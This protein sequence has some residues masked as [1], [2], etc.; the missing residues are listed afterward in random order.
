MSLHPSALEAV[1]KAFVQLGH[2][3]QVTRLTNET[4][5]T[6]EEYKAYYV[7]NES[8]RQVLRDHN[9]GFARREM[10]LASYFTPTHPGDQLPHHALLPG[11]AL[12]IVGVKDL[13]GRDAEYTIVDNE[14][15]AAQ[16]VSL[17]AYTAD[18]EDLGLWSAGAYKALILR[19]AADLAKAV[20]GRINERQLQEEAYAA[21][22]RAAKLQDSRS[23][24]ISSKAWGDNFYADQ[25]MGRRERPRRR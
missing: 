7:Y 20:T 11:D 8:R 2:D 24:N 18:V 14:I 3:V 9:W 22:I 23:V 1:N 15:H 10:S 19:L 6:A 4:G 12:A 13:D 17:V 5:A 16:P 25:M 21:E